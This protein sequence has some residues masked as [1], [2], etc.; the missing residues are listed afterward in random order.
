[1]AVD[2]IAAE[3]AVRLVGKSLI[4][5]ERNEYD[6]VFRF[7]QGALLQVECPWRILLNGRIA[8]GGADHDQ[9]FGQ[10]EPVDGP[11]ESCRLLCDQTIQTVRIRE[12]TADLTIGFSGRGALEV[13][14]NSSGYEGWQFRD[15]G[16]G[17]IALGGG[18]LASMDGGR[19]RQP[20]SNA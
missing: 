10:P 9:R 13:L 1:M 2:D 19:N 3:I 15:A 8:L 16:F 4:Q 7:A 12:D 18:E 5:V 6:W 14:N 11:S 20:P 17:V